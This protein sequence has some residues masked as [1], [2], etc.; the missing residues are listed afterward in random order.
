MTNWL[1]LYFEDR[2]ILSCCPS[3]G[4]SAV[5]ALPCRT[6]AVHAATLA[7]S[8]VCD[9]VG[10]C[11]GRAAASVATL[12]AAGARISAGGSAGG[13]CFFPHPLASDRTDARVTPAPS[14]PRRGF[15]GSPGT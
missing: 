3:A 9:G 2:T 8:W 12:P 15:F 13:G 6:H 14:N 10:L 5:L 1:S 7:S 11:P 4:L